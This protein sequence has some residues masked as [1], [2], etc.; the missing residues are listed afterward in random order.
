MVSA[1]AR[2][3]N[4]NS[5]IHS[6]INPSPLS[7]FLYPYPLTNRNSPTHR[8]PSPLPPPETGLSIPILKPPRQNLTIIII[9]PDTRTNIERAQTSDVTIKL[10][11]IRE[12][13]NANIKSAVNGNDVTN[14]N[15][16]W[17]AFKQPN[18]V[19]MGRQTRFVSSQLKPSSEINR[20]S[21][22]VV[23]GRYIINLLS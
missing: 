1:T 16:S 18:D 19:G 6:F 23:I 21:G 2:N 22:S 9:C 5:F 12:T 3:S 15:L 7:V 10:R 4:S 14:G 11:T 20:N 8:Y 17:R 13:R